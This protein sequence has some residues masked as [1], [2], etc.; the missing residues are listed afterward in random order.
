ME[1]SK[2]KLAGRVALDTGA[3]K[4]IGRA[5]ALALAAEGAEVAVTARDGQPLNVKSVILT[6]NG[7]K[8]LQMFILRQRFGQQIA[9]GEATQLGGGALVTILVG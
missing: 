5:A 2:L 4:G 1:K 9:F 6:G 7:E 3:S 8:A